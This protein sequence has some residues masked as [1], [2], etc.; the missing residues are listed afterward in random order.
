MELKNI[1]QSTKAVGQITTISGEE[2]YTTVG[3]DEQKTKTL[4]QLAASFVETDQLVH[5]LKLGSVKR[6]VSASEDS[7]DGVTAATVQRKVRGQDGAAILTTVIGDTLEDALVANGALSSAA[8]K[9][10]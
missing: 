5:S 4:E 2:I 10:V 6:I 3:V 1:L 7:N 8:Q 9:L